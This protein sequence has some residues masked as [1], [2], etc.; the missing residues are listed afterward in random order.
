VVLLALKFLDLD[1]RRMGLSDM[2]WGDLLREGFGEIY[3][4]A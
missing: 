1:L 4:N 2:A 3:L